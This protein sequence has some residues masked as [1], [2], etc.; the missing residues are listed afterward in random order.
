[1]DDR[2]SVEASVSPCPLRDRVS[3]ADGVLGEGGLPRV[4][5]CVFLGERVMCIHACVVDVRTCVCV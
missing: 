2:R 5:V 4:C 1:M 3:I